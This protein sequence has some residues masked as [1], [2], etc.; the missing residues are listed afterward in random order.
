MTT[1]GRITAVENDAGSYAGEGKA[2]WLQ[3]HR[4]KSVQMDVGRDTSAGHLLT[5]YVEIHSPSTNLLC[6]VRTAPQCVV[7]Q[8]KCYGD[9]EGK[10]ERPE[11]SFPRV[12]HMTGSL[13][14]PRTS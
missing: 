10:F 12:R 1:F 2:W 11:F 6:G 13:V 3:T 7:H 4:E 5:A 8:G 14:D 9:S